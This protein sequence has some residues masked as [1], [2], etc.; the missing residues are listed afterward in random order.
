MWAVRESQGAAAA[1]AEDTAY[2]QAR[3]SYGASYRQGF[4]AGWWS[5]FRLITQAQVTR[6]LMWR[7]RAVG[8]FTDLLM[9]GVL[10]DVHA[11][12]NA[13]QSGREALHA[14]LGVWLD[15]DTDTGWEV[16]G[17]VVYGFL[18][19]TASEVEAVQK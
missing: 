5:V 17:P 14:D 13:I 11:C 19:L 8:V 12:D 7:E 2:A 6:G 9:A 10:R 18:D 4:R 15:P 1:R 16:L 3:L